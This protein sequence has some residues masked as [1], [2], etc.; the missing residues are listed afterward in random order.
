MINLSEREK[1]RER[2]GERQ[3]PSHTD[4]FLITKITRQRVQ[5]H[6]E[7]Y[8]SFNIDLADWGS[9]EGG[10]EKCFSPSK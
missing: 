10:L 7:K 3:Y 6:I 2:E 8:F 9:N 1:E 4:V 5:R